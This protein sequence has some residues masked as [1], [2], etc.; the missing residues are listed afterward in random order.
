MAWYDLLDCELGTLFVGGSGAGLH[1]VNFLHGAHALDDEVLALEADT[2]EAAEQDP[3][4]ARP[5]VEALAAY[6]GGAPGAF[7]EPCALPLAPR[8]TPFQQSVW[9]QLRAIPAG[10]TSSYG[11]VAS[12]I[13]KPGAA[14]AVGGAVGSNPISLIVPCHRVVASDGSIG[15]FASG[16]DRKRWLLAHEG[17]EG[18]AA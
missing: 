3:E 8:G 9:E 1:R 5:A 2:G 15:G 16:L 18:Y 12:A 11:E 17:V 10:A 6:F 4:A 7:D 14:R 13:G